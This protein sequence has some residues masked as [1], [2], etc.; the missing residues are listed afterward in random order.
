MNDIH[1]LQGGQMKSS[2]YIQNGSPKKPLGAILLIWI[3][4]GLGITGFAEPP[5]TITLD[6]AIEIALQNNLVLK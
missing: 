3:V 5:R 2:G 6:Q 4:S 1:P